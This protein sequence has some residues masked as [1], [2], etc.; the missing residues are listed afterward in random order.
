MQLA[1]LNDL[2]SRE[3]VARQ[4]PTS[5][6]F[7]IEL[8]NHFG[9]CTSNFRPA[10]RGGGGGTPVTRTAVRLKSPK[11][12][13]FTALGTAVRVQRRLVGYP[14]VLHTPTH[15]LTHSRLNSPLSTF[16]LT[17]PFIPALAFRAN[18]A[19]AV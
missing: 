15:R 2:I 18:P 12:S 11:S 7:D 8:I 6:L 3:P 5:T 14:V 17:S 4:N 9:L 1:L 19:H 10:M 16:T 13:M